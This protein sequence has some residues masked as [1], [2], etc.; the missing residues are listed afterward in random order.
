MNNIKEAKELY[1]KV[2]PDLTLDF[3]L[4]VVEMGIKA[5][6]SRLYFSYKNPKKRDEITE[7]IISQLKAK[8]FLVTYDEE[9]YMIK[10]T[11]WEK[12]E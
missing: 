2:Y 3:V 1:D 4:T 10:I 9:T 12:N 6:L 8:E 11:G 7:E 5:G